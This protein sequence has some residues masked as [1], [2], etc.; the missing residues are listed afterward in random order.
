M[1]REGMRLRVLEGQG[2]LWGK[3]TKTIG[4]KET[5]A[6]VFGLDSTFHSAMD[7]TT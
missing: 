7:V 3:E 1:G 4:N 2:Y 6:F 5:N